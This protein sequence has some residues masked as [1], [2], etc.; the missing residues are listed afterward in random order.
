MTHAANHGRPFDWAAPRSGTSRRGLS[1]FLLPLAAS[2]IATLLNLGL[3]ALMFESSGMPA[4][5]QQTHAPVSGPA[6]VTG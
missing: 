4:A 6:R 3:V 5:Q 1:T 2:L